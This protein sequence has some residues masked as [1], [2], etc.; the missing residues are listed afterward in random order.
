MLNKGKTERQFCKILDCNQR[1]LATESKRILG[2]LIDA[3]GK[4]RVTFNTRNGAQKHEEIDCGMD[5]FATLGFNDIP[6]IEVRRNY[7]GRNLNIHKWPSGLRTILWSGNTAELFANIGCFQSLR[8]LWIDSSS[9]RENE[10]G[11]PME[12][13]GRLETFVAHGYDVRKLEGFD[14]VKLHLTQPNHFAE[15]PRMDKLRDFTATDLSTADGI[16]NMPNLERLH[17]VDSR[18]GDISALDW[19]LGAKYITITGGF[20]HDITPIG[21]MLGLETLTLRDNLIEDIS[22]L[23]SLNLYHLDISHNPVESIVALAGH[24]HMETL[25]LR[26]TYVRDIAPLAGLPNLREVWLDVMNL[27]NRDQLLEL[28]HVERINDMEFSEALWFNKVKK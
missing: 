11:L 26:D 9:Y 22:P 8:T 10:E 12:L 28:S 21:N 24:T 16:N 14:L 13:A 15:F 4:M 25:D 3:D 1:E 27:R 5:E 2:L 23:E 20:I 17:I 6:I 19:V 18:I 7:G